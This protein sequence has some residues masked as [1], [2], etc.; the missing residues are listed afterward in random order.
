LYM[1]AAKDTKP[2]DAQSFFDGVKVD[3]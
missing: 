3:M 1:S 2:S